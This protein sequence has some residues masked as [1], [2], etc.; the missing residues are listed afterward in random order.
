MSIFILIWQLKWGFWA[1]ADWLFSLA[2]F[3]G[4]SPFSVSPL[5]WQGKSQWTPHMC[6]FWGEVCTTGEELWNYESQSLC[7]S[8]NMYHPPLQGKGERTWNLIFL[9]WVETS[10]PSTVSIW[11]QRRKERLYYP[12]KRGRRRHQKGDKWHQSSCLK[13]GRANG[14]GGKR[15]DLSLFVASQ[16]TGSSQL[17]NSDQN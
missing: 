16:I 15:R 14:Y 10:L 11:L 5:G 7:G 3:G 17:W 1:E 2:Y 4:S 9:I 13:L 12:F 6:V 8:W